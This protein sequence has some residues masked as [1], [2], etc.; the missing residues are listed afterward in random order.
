MSVSTEA[1][2]RLASSSVFC[3]RCTWP[4]CSRTSCLRV[5]SSARSAWV[6]GSGTKLE[7]DRH[8]RQQV[9]QPGG[10]RDVGLATGH[11]PHMRRIGQHQREIAVRQHVPRPASSTPRSPP[12]RHGCSR[13]RSAT[14]RVPAA[15]AWSCRTGAPHTAP[16][17]ART[18]EPPPPHCPCAR[19]DPH[20]A[21]GER[22]SLPPLL[23]RRRRTPRM[24]TLGSALPGLAA[25]G[26]IGGAS[27][28]PDPTN[29]RAPWH[30]D[31][32]DLSAD[33]PH[34]P[35]ISFIHGGSAI[36]VKN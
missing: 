16:R 13:I 2:L 25:P 36:P 12:S 15:P 23:R 34:Q 32:A 28:V 26:A 8:S 1:S 29:T 22:P 5:R 24:Q 14:R 11:V 3:S 27:G 18:A 20:S 4:D 7:P 6:A 35:A 30:H 17:P 9:G 19:R 21:G 33:G 31:E 10:V